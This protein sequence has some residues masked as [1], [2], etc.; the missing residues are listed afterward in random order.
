MGFGDIIATTRGEMIATITYMMINTAISA[1]VIGNV[2]ELVTQ[3]DEHTRMFQQTFKHLSMYMDSN[4]LPPASPPLVPTAPAPPASCLCPC[5]VC[6]EE[7]PALEQSLEPPD[8]TRNA[9]AIPQRCT[10]FRRRARTSQSLLGPCQSLLGPL[11]ARRP[12]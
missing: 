4:D 2:T 1:Y 11:T 10:Y 8:S 3:A 12:D 5:V 6:R 9:T 7:L